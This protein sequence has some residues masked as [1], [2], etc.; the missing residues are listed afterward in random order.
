VGRGGND[1]G[2]GMLTRVPGDWVGGDDDLVELARGGCCGVKG[3]V[4]KRGK[5]GM[6]KDEAISLFGFGVC[7]GKNSHHSCSVRV[8]AILLCVLLYRG[9][10]CEFKKYSSLNTTIFL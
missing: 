10:T 8:T 1:G 5:K 3:P 6:I 9:K 4:R 2:A 7:V